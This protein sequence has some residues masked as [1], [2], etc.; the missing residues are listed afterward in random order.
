MGT[1][2]NNRERRDTQQNRKVLLCTCPKLP[3]HSEMEQGH[4][5]W[6]LGERVAYCWAGF[7]KLSGRPWLDPS[8][9]VHISDSELD[10]FLLFMPLPDSSGI[11]SR[12]A[13]VNVLFCNNKNQGVQ[14]RSVYF[15][16]C[17]RYRT[18]QK[19]RC[20]MTLTYTLP[21]DVFCICPFPLLPGHWGSQPV[22]WSVGCIVKGN[23]S[24]GV[25]V[26]DVFE[27]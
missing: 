17:L 8:Q 18:G 12:F 23:S 15:L 25:M 7:H 22:F 20:Y 14:R 24:G 6:H 26:N 5:N 16:N 21:S 19:A 9:A 4:Q 27:V 10:S 1:R 13:N 11:L 3:A 2:L